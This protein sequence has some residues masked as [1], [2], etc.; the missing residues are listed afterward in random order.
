ML[1]IG[2]TQRV[3]DVK[4]YNEIRDTLDQRWSKLLN[5]SNCLCIPIPNV[6]MPQTFIKNLQ[7]DGILLSGG[8]DHET[9]FTCETACIDYCIQEKLP[10]LG[11]CHGMQFIGQYWGSTLTKIEN[12]VAVNHPV[13]ITSNPHAIP[14]GTML[15]N[16]Y[17]NFT[18]NKIPK[19]FISFA[20]DKDGHC[21]AM[22]HKELPIVTFMWHPERPPF[23][24]WF[25][26][27]L[28]NFYAKH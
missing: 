9:R 23:L 3:E 2:I 4:S 16:S 10:L 25:N 5:E 26:K 15:T 18:L 7:L 14:T 27:F 12:S 6:N 24:N 19:D 20:E 22:Y 1:K 17:H 28:E 21:E 8:N 11:I 13:T